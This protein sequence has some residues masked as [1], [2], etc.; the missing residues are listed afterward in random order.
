MQR[1]VTQAATVALAPKADVSPIVC[2]V[3]F[4]SDPPSSFF[5]KGTARR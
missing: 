5:E 4:L 2:F 1:L 3:S